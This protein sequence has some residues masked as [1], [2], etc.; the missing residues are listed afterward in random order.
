MAITIRDIDKHYY[1]IESLKSLTNSNVTTKA[2]INGG[3]LA[4]D[5]GQQLEDERLKRIKAESE[6][7]ELKQKFSSYIKSKE[8]LLDA[9]R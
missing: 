6:L 1:M 9:L 5:L 3:Y 7:Q 4:V 2:L 8:E